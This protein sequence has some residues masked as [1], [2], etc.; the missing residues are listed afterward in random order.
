MD[1]VP[2]VKARRPDVSD[3][4]WRVIKRQYEAECDAA[5]SKAQKTVADAE[6]RLAAV[7]DSKQQSARQAF[8]A[9]REGLRSQQ[10]KALTEL[11]DLQSQETYFRGLATAASS[12][13]YDPA[14]TSQIVGKLAD[15]EAAR[16]LAEK[17]VTELASDA[18]DL[19]TQWERKAAAADQ[20]Y[21]TGCDAIGCSPPLNE[22]CVCLWATVPGK[23][24]TSTESTFSACRLQVQTRNLGSGFVD[25]DDGSVDC[26]AGEAW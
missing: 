9:G 20:E 10:D 2:W 24:L 6:T 15:R 3:R 26:D 19:Q 7:R 12:A 13:S 11:R 21:Q 18:K 23:A 25:G 22:V 5:I 8:R 14:L 16:E 17:K 4:V 1:V